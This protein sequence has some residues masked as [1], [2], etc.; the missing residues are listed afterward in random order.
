MQLQTY[1]ADGRTYTNL[2]AELKGQTKADEIVLVGGHY[3]TAYS[4]PGANDNATGTAATLALARLF[5]D[6]TP[7][8]TIRFVEFAN[9]EPPF[10]WTEEMGSFVYAQRAQQRQEKIVAMLSL[11][12]MGYFSDQPGSQAYPPPLNLL[13]PDRGNFI[14]FIGNLDSGKLVRRAIAAFRRHSQFP[15]EGAAVPGW[16]P[17]IG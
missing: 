7:A 10:F 2:E 3:D 9:E 6:K 5:A 8:R 12:T 17:G 15:S 11:E 16:I 1:Q 13:Y 14:A 4:T